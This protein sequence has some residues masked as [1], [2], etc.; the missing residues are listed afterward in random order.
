MGM[1]K[2]PQLGPGQSRL[3]GERP[4]RFGFDRK[5]FARPITQN[6]QRFLFFRN[7]KRNLATPI[8]SAGIS[9]AGGNGQLSVPASKIGDRVNVNA[10]YKY[11]GSSQQLHRTV[12]A[13]VI[14]PIAR[15]SPWR[16]VLVEALSTRTAIVLVRSSCSSLVMSRVKRGV[17][18]AHVFAGGLAI[19]PNCG[20]VEY[21]FKFQTHSAVLQT[22]EHICCR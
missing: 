2:V 4:G 18:L 12:N 20:G 5:S 16:H 22:G 11:F 6:S 15:S 7:Q 10:L 17:P 19:D 21:S 14:R 8:F 13:A 9:D 3:E 1:V